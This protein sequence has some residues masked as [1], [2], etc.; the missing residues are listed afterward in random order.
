MCSLSPVTCLL[1]QKMSLHP[2]STNMKPPHDAVR[3]GQG[4]SSP[5]HLTKNRYSAIK[6]RYFQSL[7]LSRQSFPTSVKKKLGEQIPSHQ[8]PSEN[9]QFSPR[10]ECVTINRPSYESPPALTFPPTFSSGLL[11]QTQHD[12]AHSMSKQ[13]PSD[14]LKSCL[15]A[16]D[17]Q[18]F[19]FQFEEDAAQ[20]QE[21][22]DSPCES[23]RTTQLD[24]SGS[25]KFVPPHLLT[26]LD[27][28]FPT[29]PYRK[30]GYFQ[31]RTLV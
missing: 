16:L 11:E 6:S 30:P 20:G 17:S 21:E 10:S 22:D 2:P 24:K 23:E 12:V 9:R 1:P 3:S 15:P 26:K 18:E 19:I 4:E 27:E 13:G 5:T 31:S 14:N 7:N 8:G 28:E 29:S 25:S